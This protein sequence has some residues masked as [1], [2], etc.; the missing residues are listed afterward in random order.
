M[1]KIALRMFV[2]FLLALGLHAA[3]AQAQVARVF[4]SAQG[5]DSNPCSFAAPCRTFQ[6]AH[7]VV[8]AN[9]EIDV[10][11]P[12]GYGALTINKA[13]SIQGHGFAGVAVT[14]F[15]TGITI[16]AG[17]M[18]AIYLNGLLLEGNGAGWYGIWL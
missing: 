12:G 11:T 3:P 10:L 14:S 4:V 7:D 6:H 9:G 18:D 17:L 5:V 2:V 15:N 8:T 16:T 1:S 13:I